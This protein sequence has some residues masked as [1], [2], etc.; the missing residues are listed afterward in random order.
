M[1]QIIITLILISC[2]CLPLTGQHQHEFSINA[3]GGLSTL[4]L[5]LKSGKYTA[6]FGGEAGL[7]YYYF[8]NPHFGIGTGFNVA[9][10]NSD[11]T[12]DNFS[13]T[14]DS[15]SPEG[16]S[17]KF[18][19]MYNDYKEKLT[20]IMLTIPVMFQYQTN[21]KIG[22]YIAGGGKIGLPVLSNKSKTTADK[23]TTSAFFPDWLYTYDDLPQYGYGVYRN[24]SKETDI[25]LKPA[26]MISA[27]A[28]AKWKLNENMSLY[29]GGYIDYGLND[30]TKD[31]VSGDYLLNYSVSTDYP[32]G[33]TYNSLAN[34]RNNK[35]N[36]LAIGL[37]VRFSFGCK[38]FNKIE[39]PE[40]LPLTPAPTPP[41][42][43]PT[44]TPPPP[45]PPKPV[46]TPEP[47]PAPAPAPTPAP[48]PVVDNSADIA[49]LQE[50]ISHYTLSQTTQT[51]E[52]QTAMDAKV[53]ILKKHPDWNIRITGHTC[54]LGTEETNNTLGLQRAESAKAYLIA[55]GIDAKRIIS[56]EGKRDTVWVGDIND[57]SEENRKNN[58]RAVIMCE[59][60]K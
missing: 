43:P 56:I 11:I 22:F 29:T 46:V 5:D 6:N 19:Y 57:K 9:L 60:C 20:S 12:L 48:A 30:I 36:P 47:A 25:N 45:P 1:K 8:L 28:G 41:P 50:P 53:E 4:N 13:R 17:M 39:A 55:K 35:I 7:G 52:Q 59:A 18:S 3:G 38:P 32:S 23:L 24:I 15:R 21:G 16:T 10:Y 34:T 42:P 26:F 27:E 58:R 54:D 37:K 14:T 51:T 2:I 44:P 40:P 31:P 49:K 33:F